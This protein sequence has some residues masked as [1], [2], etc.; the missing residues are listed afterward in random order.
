MSELKVYLILAFQTAS[1][2]VIYLGATLISREALSRTSG[3]QPASWEVIISTLALIGLAGLLMF[4][5]SFLGLWLGLVFKAFLLISVSGLIIW[6]IYRHGF[7]TFRK[8]EHVAVLL[9][10]I[11]M[12][13][14]ILL[15]NSGEAS[16]LLSDTG[17]TLRHAATAWGT[18]RPGDNAIPYDFAVGIRNAYIPSPLHGDWLS[19]DRPPLQTGMFLLFDISP[20]SAPLSYQ[21]TSSLLQALSIP[22]GFA[23]VRAL[24]GSNLRAFI[25]S[26]LLAFTPFFILNYIY[27]WPKFIAAAFLISAMAIYFKKKAEDQ[28]AS[29]SFYGIGGTLVALAMLS[30]GASVFAVLGFGLIVLVFRRT[31]N[32]KAI[33]LAAVCA[34]LTYLPWL[35]YQTTFDPP[36]NRLAKWHL[37]DVTQIDNRSTAKTISDAYSELTF[38]AWINGRI[39][40]LETFVQ[41][42]TPDRF[43]KWMTEKNEVERDK[44]YDRL[45]G[46]AF[47]NYAAGL[48][49]LQIALFGLPLFMLINREARLLSLSVFASCVFA[50]LLIFKPGGT[51]PHQTSYMIYPAL[52]SMIAILLPKN[53]AYLAALTIMAV[54]QTA[55]SVTMLSSI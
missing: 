37:A 1:V 5:L 42:A 2:L 17:Y 43:V 32:M 49:V 16:L 39:R 40:N 50:A 41:P 26:F 22:A 38:N 36:G 15:L 6:T 14:L 55:L 35:G 48:G 47:F 24:G 54:V 20:G 45:L 12:P 30:H 10:L 18:H 13:F 27:V 25:T 19:S 11:P 53:R 3:R 51:I 8:E 34:S 23:L 29:L 33:A 28:T 9:V 31:G 52:A 7:D 4:W 21:I 44:R 46:Q